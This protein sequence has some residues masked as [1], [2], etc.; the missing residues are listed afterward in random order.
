MTND[1]GASHWSSNK[2]IERRGRTRKASD[3]NTPY[4]ESFRYGEDE[5]NYIDFIRKHLTEVDPDTDY[6]NNSM[7][8]RRIIKM[9]YVFALQNQKDKMESDEVKKG[10][11]PIT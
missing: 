4:M 8:L 1:Y 11:K 2:R 9:A 5:W 6:N 10:D 7:L 3:N